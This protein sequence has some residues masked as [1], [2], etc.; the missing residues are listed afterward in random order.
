MVQIEAMR[1]DGTFEA[2]AKKERLSL[3]KE[4]ARLEKFV[5]GIKEMSSLP[6][7]V[8]VIDPN[9]EAIAV[10]EANKLGITLIAL[11]DTNCDPDKIDMPIPGNDDAIRSIQLI[12]RKITDSCLEGMKRRR[13]MTRTGAVEGAVAGAQGAAPGPQVEVTRRPRAASRDKTKP[14]PAKAGPAKASPAKPKAKTK[15]KKAEE[16]PEGKDE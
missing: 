12:T 7:V 1:T 13:E 4:H 16:K 14:G 11:L 3:E 9:K 5:G 15:D 10:A 8:F 6:A 2:L